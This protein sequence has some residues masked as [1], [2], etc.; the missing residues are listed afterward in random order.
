MNTRYHHCPA[1]H[2]DVN[3]IM[4]GGR[5]RCPV[6]YAE[7]PVVRSFPD[8]PEEAP[9]TGQRALNFIGLVLLLVLGI[10]AL[11]LAVAFIGC[12]VVAHH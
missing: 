2:Q 3:F 7:F 6:C 11:L 9:S 4:E 12:I 1:C 5:K 8:P 10:P